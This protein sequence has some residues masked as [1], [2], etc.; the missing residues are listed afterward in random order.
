MKINTAIRSPSKSNRK[1]MDHL[2]FGKRNAKISCIIGKRNFRNTICHIIVEYL[3]KQR[4]NSNILLFHNISSAVYSPHKTV[5]IRGETNSCR[6]TVAVLFILP[7]ENCISFP[8]SAQRSTSV[9]IFSIFQFSAQPFQKT[10]REWILRQHIGGMIINRE[11]FSNDIQHETVLKHF[12]VS[13]ICDKN[14][15]HIRIN[16]NILSQHPIIFKASRA[17][18]HP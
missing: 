7:S 17:L 9:I 6:N 4:R 12:F 18:F 8:S 13:G 15:I 5:M 2:T 1:L 10:I 3:H 14:H 11:I 16:N